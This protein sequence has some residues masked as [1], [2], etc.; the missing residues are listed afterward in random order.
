MVAYESLKTKEKLSWVNLKVVS[1]AYGSGRLGFVF[2]FFFH[3]F[4]L[5]LYSFLRP[6]GHAIYRQKALVLEMQE[7]QSDLQEG[8][9]GRT[10]R[11]FCQNQH[12]LDAYR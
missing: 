8:V 4:I 5:Y 1:V 6:D 10:Y 2:V 3:S 11:R 9:D 12:F 7:S